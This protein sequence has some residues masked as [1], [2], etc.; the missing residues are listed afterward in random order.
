MVN[1][2]NC[3]IYTK[4]MYIY[5]VYVFS[6]LTLLYSAVYYTVYVHISGL[7]VLCTHFTVQYSVLYSICT[8][9]R[10]MLGSIVFSVLPVLY[11]VKYPTFMYIHQ[12]YAGKYCI[13]CTP[14]TVQYTI[15][16][17]YIYQ[18]YVG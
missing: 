6:V 16:Y 10:F 11:G 1:F 3:T 7:C 5:Q 14:C 17:M 4:F 8:Y 12:V 15:Q 9:I 2:E 13:L 18:V